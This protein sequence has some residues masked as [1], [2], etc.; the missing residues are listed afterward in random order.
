MQ[1]Y[2][3]GAFVVGILG[4]IISFILLIM[5]VIKHKKILKIISIFL[6]ISFIGTTVGYYYETLKHVTNKVNETEVEVK[7]EKKP[8]SGNSDDPLIITEKDFYDDAN[9]YYS[10]FEVKNNSKVEISKISFHI[11]FTY[12]ASSKEGTHDEHIFLLD[13]VIPPNMTVSKSYLW[14]KGTFERQLAIKNIKLT[15]IENVICY[16]NVNG[17]EKPMK[18]DELKTM[19][20]NIK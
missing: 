15:K 3:L 10:E 20:K 16:V 8:A 2:Q 19:L 17:E 13:S 12:E 4:I 5:S 14:R 18:V 7:V 1:N 6:F 9:Y 11:I